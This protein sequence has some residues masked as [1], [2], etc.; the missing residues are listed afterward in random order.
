MG[1]NVGFG[2]RPPQLR[3]DI[4]LFVMVGCV[5]AQ[6]RTLSTEE[7][8]KFREACHVLKNEK[9]AF[10]PDDAETVIGNKLRFL[11][12]DIAREEN[13]PYS[14]AIIS[15]RAFLFALRILEQMSLLSHNN[16]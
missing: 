12:T 11:A 2:T 16:A 3:I 9:L 13:P 7:W 5:R 4:R 14:V 1:R 10:S 8:R 15:S 6:L